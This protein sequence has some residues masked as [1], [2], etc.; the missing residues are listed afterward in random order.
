[1]QS[2]MTYGDSKMFE[3]NKDL[4]EL[5]RSQF[6]KNYT[7]NNPNQGLLAFA[8]GKAYKSHQ[9][10]I[11]LCEQGFGEDAFALTRVLLEIAVSTEYIFRDDTFE[12]AK[13]FMSYDWITRRKLH[14][15]FFARRGLNIKKRSN[16]DLD[17]RTIMKEAKEAQE[18]YSYSASRGWADVG[19]REM[20]KELGINEPY[21]T[22]YSLQSD[23]LHFSA[24]TVNNYV[25]MEGDNFTV[26][27]TK[28][29]NWV[30]QALAV[31]FTAFIRITSLWDEQ[32]HFGIEK[33]LQKLADKYTEAAE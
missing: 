32:F 23:L 21:M 26:S 29:D 18:K 22:S 2:D 8:A 10:V 5:V 3:V 31:A 9:A 33:E 6:G 15:N 17:I 4:Q 27:V 7:I 30:D 25:K 14:K 20:A 1:M 28:S 24:N 11:T 13:R 16:A 19:F 12:R